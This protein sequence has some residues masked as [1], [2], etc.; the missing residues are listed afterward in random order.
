MCQKN[1]RCSLQAEIDKIHSGAEYSVLDFSL[2]STNGIRY[3]EARTIP[4][5]GREEITVLIRDITEQKLVELELRKNEER[6]RL[7]STV[8]SDYMYS[9]SLDSNGNLVLNWVTGAFTK[10][11]GYTFDEYIAVGGW[12]SRVYPDDR[13]TDR[14]DMDKLSH[15]WPVVSEIRT[16]TKQG[17]VVWVRSYAH[18]VWDQAQNKLIGI[19][20]AVHDIT[21]EKEA[22]EAL[23]ESEARYRYLFEQNPAPMLIYDR[24]SLQIMAVNA[25]FERSYGYS[26]EEALTLSLVDLY[27]EEEKQNIRKLI[28]RLKGYQNV[29]EW[30]HIKKDGSVSII[31]ACSHD[32]E[33]EG[34]PARVAVITDVTE[35]K[36]AEDRIKRL[37]IELE[38]RV[39]DRT[40][41]L[42]AMN[43]ELEAF[44]YSVSHDLRAPLR[45]MSGYTHFL[46]ED[47]G[48]LLPPEGLELLDQVDHSVKWMDNLIHGLLK[49]SRFGRQPC[50]RREVFPAQ[51]AVDAWESLAGEPGNSAFQFHI[52]NLPACQADPLLLK[53]V[54]INLLSNAVKYSKQVS[55]PMIRVGCTDE[56]T[57]TVYWVKDNGV[58]FDMKYA[59]EI[60]EA[61]HRVPDM[62]KI[63]GHGVGLSI[64]QRIIARHGGEIWAELQPGRGATFF[65]TLPSTGA[66]KA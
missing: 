61:F 36:L 22:E 63:E 39:Q 4:Q 23:I 64:V 15:N 43:D 17:S 18:P 19:Y 13:E 7:I 6:Y 55:E 49:L 27:P 46:R 47:Y 50:E 34:L 14:R 21:A 12:V 44:S 45:G 62:E 41:R 3:F 29:G 11:T 10:I 58:G 52:D 60:F 65:F 66:E 56:K 31:V 32:I 54:Y 2:P 30:H 37:N 9:T 35:R 51:I 38:K 59:H 1:Y 5:L 8:A 24:N 40:A 16:V 33:Y 57:R 53:Q 20:G 26:A 25:A 28:P 42:Q 48:K